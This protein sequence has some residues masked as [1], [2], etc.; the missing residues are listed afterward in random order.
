MRSS[1]TIYQRER[2]VIVVGA[3]ISCIGLLA[4]R[5]IPVW[6]TWVATQRIAAEDATL[7]LR[8]GHSLVRGLPVIL[9]TLM[10]RNDRYIGLAPSLIAGQSPSEASAALL[11]LI[12][13]AGATAGIRIGALRVRVDTTKGKVF[14]RLIVSGDAQGDIRGLVA[15]LASLERGPTL[16]LVKH[17]VVV[18]GQPA[19][20]SDRPE[21]LR[22]EF[23]IEG[24]GVPR[25]RTGSQELLGSAR[26]REN[27]QPPIG[28]R[29]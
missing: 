4:A 25:K 15:F 18:Q 29:R 10:R 14:P 8:R 9:D 16:L 7:A 26:P 11:S 5:G 22:I 2:R 6:H 21:A 20:P 23:V 19:A 17:L 3:A 24:L 1:L 12:S 28:T 27:L 13:G